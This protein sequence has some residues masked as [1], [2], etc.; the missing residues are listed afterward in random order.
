MREEKSARESE[1]EDS[2][3]G[4]Q[5]QRAS[6]P[7]VN[8]HPNP[9]PALAYQVMHGVDVGAALLPRPRPATGYRER[10]SATGLKVVVKRVILT[11]AG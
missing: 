10:H 9:P 8:S 3:P 5:G 7:V 2:R 11:R 6:S 4:C 1:G